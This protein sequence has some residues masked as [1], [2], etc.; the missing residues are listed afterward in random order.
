MEATPPFENGASL[1]QLIQESVLSS[2]FEKLN[3]DE[4]P[5]DRLLYRHQEIA[6][7]KIVKDG[8]N[9]IVATGTGSGKTETFF[10]TYTESSVQAKGAG[11]AW[12]RCQNAAALSDECIG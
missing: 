8:R 12:T 2:E 5:L 6:I 7:R 10:D 11:T 1:R 3:T 4:L 9:L